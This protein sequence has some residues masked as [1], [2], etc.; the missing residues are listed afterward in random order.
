ML[1]DY[2]KTHLSPH[3]IF[4]YI[5]I[6]KPFLMFA[7]IDPGWQQIGIHLEGGWLGCK[8][9]PLQHPAVA[10]PWGQWE[11]KVQHHG[12]FLF[13]SLALEGPSPTG[14]LL[15]CC[16]ACL[17]C[18]SFCDSGKSLQFPSLWE[19]TWARLLSLLTPGSAHAFPS[20]KSVMWKEFVTESAL[21]FGVW[22]E[23]L[24][25][26]IKGYWLLVTWLW[27]LPFPFY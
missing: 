3:L 23:R 2:L 1:I 7:N 11:C 6:N 15:S 12:L 24:Q 4:C 19:V 16:T 10:L 9:A 25:H 26:W 27:S 20:W 13:G 18:C 22:G 14:L 21:V 5:F 17:L 8:Q